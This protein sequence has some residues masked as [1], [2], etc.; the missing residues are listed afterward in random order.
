MMSTTRGNAAG[1]EEEKLEDEEEDDD[2]VYQYPKAGLGPAL[3]SIES[4]LRW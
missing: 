2:E 1:A 4:I 3:G